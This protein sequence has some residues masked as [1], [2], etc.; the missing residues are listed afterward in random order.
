MSPYHLQKTSKAGRVFLSQGR[1][2]SGSHVAAGPVSANS[3]AVQAQRPARTPRPGCRCLPGSP[4]RH[5]K[6]AGPRRAR[7]RRIAVPQP[8][9]Q[10]GGERGWGMPGGLSLEH[11]ALRTGSR[12]GRSMQR[13]LRIFS[14]LSGNSL[15]VRTLMAGWGRTS[16]VGSDSVPCG[17]ETGAESQGRRYLP[18]G[19]ER[20]ECQ[21]IR[22]FYFP[23]FWE[24]GL[25]AFPI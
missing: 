25:A 22:L 4:R 20:T 21:A 19:Y 14:T 11:S 16:A 6:P 9:R 18:A 1:L 12:Q 2:S 10:Q 5:K 8:R 13:A 7:P 23:R 17:G 3:A 15:S 24:C